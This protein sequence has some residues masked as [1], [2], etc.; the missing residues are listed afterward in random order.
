MRQRD[1]NH[2]ML[3]P[4]MEQ[5]YACPF[6]RQLFTK[7]EVSSCPDCDVKVLPLAELPP[8]HDAEL[9]EPPEVVPPEHEMLSWTFSG[10]GRGL[11]LLLAVLGIGMFLAPWLKQSSPEIQVWSG[12]EFARRLGWLWAAGVSWLVMIALVVSRRTIK[13]MRGAR[14]A[15][16]FLA[17]ADLLTVVMR[18]AMTPRQDPFA[19]LRFEYGWGMY[20]SAIVAVCALIVAARF[21]GSLA[22]MPTG[23]P[24]RGDETLH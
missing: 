22:D 5:L 9:I 21:G 4:L 23:Q 16:G 3:G 11:L 17:A 6:C 19:P 10:R 20:G 13:Q 1:A 7:G 2:A 12:F 18:L 8:S 24:R 15:V 14:V